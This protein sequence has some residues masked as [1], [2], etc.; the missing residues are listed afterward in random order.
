MPRRVYPIKRRLQAAEKDRFFESVLSKQPKSVLQEAAEENKAL[1]AREEARMTRHLLEDT[2]EGADENRARRK[3]LQKQMNENLPGSKK[4]K[5]AII[6]LEQE[7][8]KQK[9][10]QREA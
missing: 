6:K 3:A 10:K 8:R 4:R 5:E 2:K 7:A 9:F 1:A